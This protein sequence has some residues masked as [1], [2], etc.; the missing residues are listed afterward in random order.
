MA[1]W[2]PGSLDHGGL[3]RSPVAASWP[4]SSS[5]S[6]GKETGNACPGLSGHF[7]LGK[8]L[9]VKLLDGG[10]M[11]V[12]LCE[13]PPHGS[14]SARAV[15]ARQPPPAFPPRPHRPARPCGF[16][17]PRPRSGRRVV[18]P[19]RDTPL[20][21]SESPLVLQEGRLL[22]PPRAAGEGGPALP[23]LRSCSPG[24]YPP[25]EAGAYSRGC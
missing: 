18:A 17:P 5:A 22:L 16:H 9:R 12:E 14:P 10:Q 19:A 7:L 23:E 3:S 15:G 21:N 24:I 8:Y 6:A 25:N 13:E 2:P 4:V 11:S 20:C 1:V